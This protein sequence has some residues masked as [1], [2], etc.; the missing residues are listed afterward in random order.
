MLLLVG[1]GNPGVK[2]AA[3]RHNAGFMAVDAIAEAH[4][5]S[6]PKSKF[7]GE[8]REG[9]IGNVRALTLKPQTFYNESGNSVKAAAQFYKV[10]LENIIVFH[11]E[12]DLAPGKMKMKLGGGLA[13]NNGL[14]STAAHMG[15]DF[16]RVR[17]GIGHPGRKE[18]VTPF[19]LGD[20]SKAEKEDWLETTLSRLGDAAIH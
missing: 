2:H 16:W 17:L 20:F 5:F 12:I 6:A 8:I 14:K 1:L 7:K 18:A 13:G 19:V 4:G 9:R 10:P 11:D 15:P 3:Q